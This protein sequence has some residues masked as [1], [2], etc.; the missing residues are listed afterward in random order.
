MYFQGKKFKKSVCLY[1]YNAFLL[2]LASF[3][4]LNGWSDTNLVN[5]IFIKTAEPHQAALDLN[6]KVN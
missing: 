2:C 5:T 1:V 4:Y 3:Y 6:S